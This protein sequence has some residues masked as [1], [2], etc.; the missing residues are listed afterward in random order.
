MENTNLK[1]DSPMRTQRWF[2]FT[3]VAAVIGLTACEGAISP[4]PETPAPVEVSLQ[5]KPSKKS[6]S[7]DPVF[8]AKEL[9]ITDLSVVADPYYTHAPGDAAKEGQGAWPLQTLVGT[10]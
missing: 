8:P 7:A 6:P 4:Q 9:F 2:T 1:V 10:F 5:A 3:G